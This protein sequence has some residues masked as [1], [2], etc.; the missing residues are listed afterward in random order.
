MSQDLYQ[1]GI[2]VLN[3]FHLS[4]VLSSQLGSSDGHLPP[5]TESSLKC[6]FSEI[7][8]ISVLLLVISKFELESMQRN[9]F[10]ILESVQIG[11]HRI[12][13]AHRNVLC[14][15]ESW[16][17]WPEGVSKSAN[18]SARKEGVSYTA[19]KDIDWRHLNLFHAVTSDKDVQATT[20]NA[21][22]CV[23]QVQHSFEIYPRKHW[24]PVVRPGSWERNIQFEVCSS[25]QVSW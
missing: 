19:I 24:L 12:T 3:F 15:I 16:G 25:S 6:A 2:V 20:Q 5:T 18:R 17:V 11:F 13:T 8:N 21:V 14:A 10:R 1:H 9:F 4:F 23:V 22:F 7:P